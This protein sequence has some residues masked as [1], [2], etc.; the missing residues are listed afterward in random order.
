[1]PLPNG[2]LLYILSFL[3]SWFSCY[4]PEYKRTW[5]FFPY[6]APSSVCID[7]LCQ[8]TFL[9]ST[10]WVSFR[11]VWGW[12]CGVGK[13]SHFLLVATLSN[14]TTILHSLP[15]SLTWGGAD[16]AQWTLAPLP[17]TFLLWTQPLL[18]SCSTLT[19][20]HLHHKCNNQPSGEKSH[21]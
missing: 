17:S 19:C 3:F 4:Q 5:I 7:W 12:I 9:F 21:I 18:N 2:H 8:F 1:M 14:A 15:P 11:V 16:N 6:I 13:I 20:V 10:Y